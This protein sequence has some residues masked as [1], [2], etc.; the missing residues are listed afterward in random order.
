MSD[1]S[2]KLTHKQSLFVSAYIGV[3][4]GNATEAA[5]I[6]GYAGNVDTL[7]SVGCENLTKHY[8]ADAIA[9]ARDEARSTGISVQQSRVDEQHLRWEL[10]KQ[11][12]LERAIDPF[13]ADVA[14]GSTGLIIKQL[15]SVTYTYEKDPDDPKSKWRQVKHEVFEAAL[16][17]TMLKAMNDLEKATATELGQI[18]AKDSVELNATESFMASLRAF[19]KGATVSGGDDCDA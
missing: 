10:L 16:D 5:R 15:K 8:I 12:R 11:V 3:A 13:Y 17:A 18:V 6:A 2:P 1:S 9:A 7:K 19:G 14:G 4:N